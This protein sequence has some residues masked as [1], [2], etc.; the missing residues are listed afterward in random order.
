MQKQWGGEGGLG[1][2][3]PLDWLLLAGPGLHHHGRDHQHLDGPAQDVAPEA[4]E[5]LN[6]IVGSNYSQ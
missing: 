2:L 5:E 1:L 4:S 3:E 6:I